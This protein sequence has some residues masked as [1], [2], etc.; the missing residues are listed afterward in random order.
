MKRIVLA[1]WLLC[2]C[3]TGHAA[4]VA[5]VKL[6]DSVHLGSRELQLNGAGVRTKIFFDLYVAALYLDKKQTSAAAVL[7]DAGEKR[8]ALHLLRDISADHLL[9]AFN[10]AIVANHTAAEL[11]ALDASL[12]EFAA[13]FRTMPEVKKGDVITLDHLPASGTL[14][15]VNGSPKGLIAGAAFNAALL[16]VWLGEKPAQVDLKQKLL[17]GQ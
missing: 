2:L 5:G 12:K 11:S 15:S 17:G 9:N 13:I 10:N 4:E 16:K 1:A 8:M 3:A 7:D 6:A 14:V